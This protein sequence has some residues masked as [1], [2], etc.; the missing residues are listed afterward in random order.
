MGK[1]HF[2][3][4]F[5]F[6]F[7]FFFFFFSFQSRLNLVA[8]QD[9]LSDMCFHPEVANM[10]GEKTGRARSVFGQ[11][12]EITSTGPLRYDIPQ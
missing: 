6:C 7:A 12:G 11:A 4:R 2:W 5:C 1:A 9:E 3:L 8:L 10:P